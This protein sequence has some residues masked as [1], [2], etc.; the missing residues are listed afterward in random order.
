M[1]LFERRTTMPKKLPLF[2]LG[3]LLL[4][5]VGFAGEAPA[6]GSEPPAFL[7]AEG[8]S[9]QADAVT[10]ALADLGLQPV[11]QGHDPA[12]CG[13]CLHCTS[14]NVCFGQLIGDPCGSGGTCQAFDGCALYNC[15]RCANVQPV[16][17]AQ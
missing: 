4:A 12:T 16:A 10:T 13:R 8:P 11:F 15:C 14:T 9:C 3:L 1:A 2:C 5:G 7:A 17:A 6:A